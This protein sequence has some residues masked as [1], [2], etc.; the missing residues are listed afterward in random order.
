ALHLDPASA[1][2][3]RRRSGRTGPEP[4]NRGDVHLPITRGSPTTAT[5][6]WP[7]ALRRVRP[8][9]MTS[10]LERMRTSPY[11]LVYTGEEAANLLALSRSNMYERVRVGDVDSIRLG[12][13]LFITE[14]TVTD[15]IGIHPPTPA[16]LAQ[17]R[18]SRRA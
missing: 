3:Q 16:E 14:P 18:K 4:V 12:R 5:M 10:P 13:R 7:I 11:R 15:L 2:Q 6:R 8:K 9:A 17:Q 1:P